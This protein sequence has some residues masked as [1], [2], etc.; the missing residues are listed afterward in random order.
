ML[1]PRFCPLNIYE[2]SAWSRTIFVPLSLLWAHRPT[3]DTPSEWQID[4]LFLDGPSSLPTTMPQ[5]E[6]LDELTS[7]S[8]INWNRIFTRLDAAWKG[9][10]RWKLTPFRGMAIRRAADWMIERFS[11]SDGLGAIFPPMVWSVV[12]LKCLGYS[13]DAP[14]LVQALEQLENLVI[15]ENGTDRLQPCHSPVWDTSIATI[16][17]Q[18]W[19]WLV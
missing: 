6:Q 8:R 2:M 11:D 3:I 7:P 16:A 15:S 9:L 17:L 14:I 1:L 19:D 4:E 13:D 5:S 18:N 12:A 10:E